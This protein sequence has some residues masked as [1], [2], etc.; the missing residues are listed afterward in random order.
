MERDE[1]HECVNRFFFVEI[2]ER[3]DVE[4]L[5]WTQCLRRFT[6]RRFGSVSFLFDT[7]MQPTVKSS[8]PSQSNL[9]RVFLVPH[10]IE[11]MSGRVRHLF[12]HLRK[13]TLMMEKAQTLAHVA[14][15][16]LT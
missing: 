2:L 12:T 13:R 5:E 11:C 6:F 7:L 10:A 3:A 15:G 8:R 4:G 9:E 14:C 1:E 16:M